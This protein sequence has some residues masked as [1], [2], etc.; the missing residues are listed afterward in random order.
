MPDQNVLAHQIDELGQVIAL[1]RGR[2]DAGALADVE[3]A[4][5]RVGERVAVSGDKTVVALAGATGSGKSSLFNALT[6]SSWAQA[7]VLR[8]TTSEAMA[9]VWGIDVPAPLLDW[10]GIGRRH[11]VAPEPALDGLVLVDL[12]D[13]DS[14]ETQHRE[15]VDRLVQAV[16]ALVWVVDPEKYADSALHDGYLRTLASHANVMMVVFN[17][18]DR[19]ADA[20]IQRCARDMR[21]LLNDD[22]LGASPIMTTSVATGLGVP[23]LRGALSRLVA[24]KVAMMARLSADV[25]AA[26]RSVIQ[27]L[28]PG[29][30]PTMNRKL[31]ASVT[32]ALGEVCGV[33]A[34][35][36]AAHGSWLRRGKLATGWPFVSWV[37]HLRPDPLKRL[38]SGARPEAAEAVR[39]T[40]VPKAGAVQQMAVE[41][42]VRGLVESV[43]DGMPSAWADAVRQ[44]GD[45]DRAGLVDALDVA[46]ASAELDERRGAW[47]WPLFRVVQWVLVACVVVGILWLCAGPLAAALGLPTPP[48]VLWLRVPAGT[49]LLLGGLV[50]GFA[51]GLLGRLFVNV[52]ARGRAASARRVLDKAVGDVVRARMVAPIQSEL[53]RYT[54]ALAAV[55][56]LR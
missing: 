47:W 20:D 7:A 41:G 6:G 12:P 50:A 13:Y 36:E 45:G 29:P 43:A 30:A 9:A 3:G 31:V 17:K 19:L 35:V 32:R 56:D 21:K 44:A 37:A 5:R 39:H 1:C 26:A 16:D 2:V 14:L 10:L 18:T 38:R 52:G 24:A 4:I 15:T 25:K 28:G 51:L 27:A 49:W 11:V 34:L 54:Q 40:S 48:Q 55:R 46:V 42:Q 22:G 8:P 23:E 53:D 33:P